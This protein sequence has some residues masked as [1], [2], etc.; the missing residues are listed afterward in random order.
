MNI[1][2]SNSVLIPKIKPVVEEIEKVDLVKVKPKFGIKAFMKNKKIY[3]FF[4]LVILLSFFITYFGLS[5]LNFYRKTI[6]VKNDVSTLKQSLIDQDLNKAEENLNI[7]T[8]SYQEFKSAY[9]PFRAFNKV[10]YFGYYFNDFE[11]LLNA[12]NYSLE[13]GKILI[14]TA[15]P[16]ADIIGLNN[17]SQQ[18]SEQTTQDRIDF[19]I[20]T[21]PDLI[22]KV[23]ELSNKVSLISTELSGINPQKYPEKFKGFEI[24]TNIKNGLEILVSLDEM[25]KNA[26][27]LLES[28]PYLLGVNDERTYMVLFQNDKELRPTGGFIT[29]Y[30]I[31]KVINGRFDP[32]LSSDIY[33]LDNNYKPKITAP[34]EIVKYIKGPYLLSKKWKLRDMNWSPDFSE[35]MKIF[36]QESQTAGIPKVDGII[37]VDTY[38]LVYLLDAIGPIQVPGYGEFST[39]ITPECNCPQVIY[40]LE[41][42]ADIEGPIVWSENEPDKIVYAPENYDNRKKIIGPLMNSILSNALGQPADKMPLLF[43][44]IL[45]SFTEKHALFYFFDDKTQNAISSFGIGGT[46]KKEYSG[47][48]LSI[49]DANLGGRKSNLYVTQEISQEI[50]VSNDGSVVKILNITYK[51]PEKYDGWLNSVLPNWVRIYVPKGSE[52]LEV[53]GLEDRKDSYEE[54]DKT[55]FAGFFE[56]RPQGISN[57][58]VK[59]KLPFK[60][61][62]E[63]RLFIQKQPGTDMPLYQIKINGNEDEFFLKTDQEIISKIGK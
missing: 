13:S 20:K 27:P 51:N 58:K 46:I 29:A 53:N 37:A 35:S 7:L 54:F 41:S 49:I 28:A 25:L 48:Y 61:S 52:I 4:F 17:S 2:E 10:P 12:G 36:S 39:K 50:E 33:N 42:F 34:D 21:I 5:F 38:V 15:K 11:H 18:K 6:K 62:D 1:Q 8:A 23:D 9:K 59:Y 63:Y 40:N 45:R 56:L 47:D 32:V 22:P 60:V 44:A 55:V 3:A 26:K 19:V 24:R 14:S 16:Y 31:A 43:D 57:V 30:S